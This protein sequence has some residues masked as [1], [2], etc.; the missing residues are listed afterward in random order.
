MQVFVSHWLDEYLKITNDG[1]IF[2]SMLKMSL[3]VTESQ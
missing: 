1:K 3:Q 2:R